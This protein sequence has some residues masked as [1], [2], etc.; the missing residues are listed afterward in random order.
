[1]ITAQELLQI[2]RD[3]EKNWND[4]IKRSAGHNRF[5]DLEDFDKGSA[6]GIGLLIHELEKAIK[7]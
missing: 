1:M 4:D 7:Q 6:T 5:D 2:A 3:F